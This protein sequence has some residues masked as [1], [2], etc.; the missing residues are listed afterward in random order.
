M[1]TNS[2]IRFNCVCSPYYFLTSFNAV[3]LFISILFF[4][5]FSQPNLLHDNLFKI[6]LLVCYLKS[7]NF[8][9]TLTVIESLTYYHKSQE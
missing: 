2:S 9:E 5:Y 1:T 3:Y 6:F 8:F 4:I 7:S